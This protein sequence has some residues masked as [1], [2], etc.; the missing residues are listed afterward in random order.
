MASKKSNF[1][2]EIGF[3]VV[4]L[5]SFRSVFGVRHLKTNSDFFYFSLEKDNR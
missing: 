1:V 2:F 5:K 4:R 3:L